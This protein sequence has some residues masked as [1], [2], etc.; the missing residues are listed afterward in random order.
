ML[1]GVILAMLVAGNVAA[2]TIAN[3]PT[4]CGEHGGL[5]GWSDA[6]VGQQVDGLDV[7]GLSAIVRDGRDGTWL[8]LVDN[9]GSSPARFITLD[10]PVD[11]TALGEPHPVGMTPLT[12][13]D[14][15]LTGETTDH[16]GLARLPGGDLLVTSETEPSIRRYSADGAFVEE[17]PV[18]DRFR[19]APAGEA[20]G[21]ATFESLALS[22]SGKRLFTAN[23]GPLAADGRTSDGRGWHRILRYAMTRDDLTPVAEYA[24][25]SEADQSVVEIIA[26]TETRLLVLERGFTLLLG[27]TIRL[28]ETD[29]AGAADVREVAS[30]ADGE[31][32]PLAKRLLVDL[33]HCPAQ[34]APNP[35][36]Q[37]HPL[38]DNVEAMALGPVARNGTRPLVLVSDD[39]FNAYQ[40]TRV[41]ALSLD[42]LRRNG[43]PG[44]GRRWE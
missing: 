13:P 36:L 44:G 2:Q 29:L 30:L 6:L 38:L 32:V 39:N 12:H 23:E 7:G 43:G 3:E 16:E 19:V 22:P 17:Y 41:Y 21:N 9:Q 42:I 31:I 18:P 1:A 8:A 14:L 26:L 5:I 11:G 15:S 35:G 40:V 20:E 33:S 34:D 24:W 37:L 4:A 10:I 28:F 27:S 25:Q